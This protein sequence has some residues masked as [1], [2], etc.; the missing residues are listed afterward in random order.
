MSF[1]TKLLALKQAAGRL[2]EPETVSRAEYDRLEER[3][4]SVVAIGRGREKTIQRLIMERDS[5]RAE[6]E[7][8]KADA[9]AHRRSK[10]NLKQFRTGKAA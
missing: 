6:A 9:E 7:A 4:S 1:L 5:A 8:N 2:P 10:A 3:F